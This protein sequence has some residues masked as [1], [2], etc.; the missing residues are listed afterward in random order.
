M[1]G[2]I[3]PLS[4]PMPRWSIPRRWG[5]RLGSARSNARRASTP[6][7]CRG[8][9]VHDGLL[10]TIALVGALRVQESP[11]QTVDEVAPG[12]C[13]QAVLTEGVFQAK[14]VAVWLV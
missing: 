4:R 7:R 10:T 14:T 1:R 12:L 9:V 5:S 3:G 13:V 11:I 8:L 2:A 6:S